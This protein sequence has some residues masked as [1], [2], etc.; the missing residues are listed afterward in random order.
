MDWQQIILLIGAALYFALKNKGQDQQKSKNKGGQKKRQE[1]PTPSLE[2]IL[3]ELTGEGPARRPTPPPAPMPQPEPKHVVQKVHKPEPVKVHDIPTVKLEDSEEE[4][5][6]SN[7]PDFDLRQAVIY[8]AI[9]N[10]PYQ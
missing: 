9:L 4:E 5:S 7:K 6:P 8:D 2:D 3:R 1:R 10:R